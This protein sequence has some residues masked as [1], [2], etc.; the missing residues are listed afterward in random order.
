VKKSQVLKNI[1]S[2]FFL[3]F[4][5][6]I[7]LQADKVTTLPASE[8]L[9]RNL[10]VDL[11]KKV[12]P[13]VVNISTT[14]IIRG[15]AMYRNPGMPVD[16]FEEFF[17]QFM[18]G[19][20]YRVPDQKVQSLGSGFI[21]DSSGLIITNFHV[22]QNASDIQ[23]QLTEKSK[24]TFK[25]KVVGTDERTDIA[26]I[27]INADTKL[28]SVALGDSDKIEVGEW[29]AAF[30]NPLG[31]G[32][33]ISKGIISAKDRNIELENSYYPFLQTDTAINPGNSGGPLV[34]T[35]GEVIG[36]NA[37][38]DVR[39]QGIGFAIPINVVKK[40][41]PEL[42]TKGKITRGFLGVVLQDVNERMAKQFKISADKGAFVV[43]VAP[44]SP[45]AKGGIEPYD[46][47]V[48]FNGKEIESSKSL[49]NSVAET[50]IGSSVKIKVIREGKSKTLTIKIV[51]RSDEIAQKGKG[52]GPRD[53]K[54][55]PGTTAPSQFGFT[56]DDLTPDL[57]EQ[58]QLESPAKGVVIVE[59]KP[60]SLADQAGIQVGDIILDI[61]RIAVKNSKDAEKLL[62]K[63]K[64]GTVAFRILRGQITM[65]VFMEAD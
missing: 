5:V 63:S 3:S 52:A 31:H 36:V 60:G 19:G 16:P 64:G 56:F 38:I 30:G 20:G 43:N 37:A 24:K 59:V 7:P 44:G 32:H 41:L 54:E 10:F 12:N 39:G 65:L 23:V 57:A 53:D 1:I 62:K 50:P 22:I 33:S 28:T 2:G 17:G 40:L 13:S 47:I 55:T 11:S 14:M 58:L 9:P 34:S 42:K 21:I 48:E 25:A 46:V 4:L 29:V 8:Y 45:A 49:T 51:E 61:N 6:T 35:A 18:G 27:K 15:R 26:L